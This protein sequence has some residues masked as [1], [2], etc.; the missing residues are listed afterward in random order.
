MHNEDRGYL[1]VKTFAGVDYYNEPDDPPPARVPPGRVGTLAVH[2]GASSRM[3]LGTRLQQLPETPAQAKPGD[4][5]PSQPR[6]S[7]PNPKT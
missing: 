7:P 3:C 5:R 1:P 6:R 4:P 2:D